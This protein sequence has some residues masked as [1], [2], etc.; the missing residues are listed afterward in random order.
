MLEEENA[1]P[2]DRIQFSYISIGAM[3]DGDDF[4]TDTEERTLLGELTSLAA[5]SIMPVSDYNAVT[6]AD[7]ALKPGQGLVYSYEGYGY[8]SLHLLGQSYQ[9][10][11]AGSFRLCGYFNGYVCEF[12]HF[13]GAG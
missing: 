9:G 4:I 2:K 13:G 10:G 6:G 3:Q 11:H 12:H 5:I 8:D 1:S 7:A